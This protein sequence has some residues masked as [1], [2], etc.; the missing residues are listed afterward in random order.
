MP[1]FQ[2]LKQLNSTLYVATHP[3]FPNQE[4]IRG[5]TS[6][7]TDHPHQYL[8]ICHYKSMVL[9]PDSLTTLATQL[10]M[11]VQGID[12]RLGKI[13]QMI[14]GGLDYQKSLQE[15]L[16]TTAETREWRNKVEIL[17]STPNK[18]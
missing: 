8:F 13:Q 17:Y 14:V 9:C 4:R 1:D 16:K 6:K 15:Y 18:S 7:E 2:Y 5:E 12:A 3:F 10:D 11:K